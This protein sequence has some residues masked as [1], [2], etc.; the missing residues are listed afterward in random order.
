MEIEELLKHEW[1]SIPW[2]LQIH[3]QSDPDHLTITGPVEEG[4]TGK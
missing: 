3:L 4:G 1:N 2:I